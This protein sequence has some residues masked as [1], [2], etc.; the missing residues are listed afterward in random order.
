MRTGRGLE[1]G[2][3]TPFGRFAAA[4][5]AVAAMAALAFAP[6]AGAATTSRRARTVSTAQDAE[7]GTILV[8]GDTVYTLKPSK[9]ST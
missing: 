7:L 1:S 4:I 2:R 6:G 9:P 8:A 5:A 3:W